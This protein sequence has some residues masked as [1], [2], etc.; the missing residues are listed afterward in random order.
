MN[1]KNNQFVQPP[2]HPV[3]TV[4]TIREAMP[5]CGVNDVDQ[6]EGKTQAERLAVDLFCND[7]HT[8]VDKTHG[9]LDSDF[10]IYSDLTQTQ[11]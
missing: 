4:Y 8:C 10:K 6:F 3:S 9:E 1:N 2:V 5:E 7:F 11:G